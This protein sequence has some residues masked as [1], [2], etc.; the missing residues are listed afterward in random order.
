MADRLISWT[1]FNLIFA[2]LPFCASVSIHALNGSLSADTIA[3]SPEL[4]FYILMICAAALSDL[5]DSSPLG[6]YH[7]DLA[8]KLVRVFLLVGAISSAFFYG[9]FVFNEVI[10]PSDDEFRLRLLYPSIWA[11]ICFSVIC[12]VV[13]IM[14]ELAEASPNNG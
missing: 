11:S 3:K 14:I 1:T 2:L 9:A 12:L 13:Q 5:S 8:L 10:G 4:L 7:I 6:H